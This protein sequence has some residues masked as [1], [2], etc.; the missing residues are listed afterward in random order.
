[1]A[2]IILILI[3]ILIVGRHHSQSR[4]CADTLLLVYLV[5]G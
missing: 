4:S 1:M 3:I 5:L 2:L